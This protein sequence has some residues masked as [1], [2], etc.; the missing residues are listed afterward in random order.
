MKD[1]DPNVA[2]L[3]PHHVWSPKLVMFG[4][5]QASKSILKGTEVRPIPGLMGLYMV[6]CIVRCDIFNGFFLYDVCIFI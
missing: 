6:F 4:F 2:V 3:H 5:K 1:D